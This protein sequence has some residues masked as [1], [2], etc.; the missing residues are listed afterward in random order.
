[1]RIGELAA[2]S[3]LPTSTIRY[4]EPIGVLPEPTRVSGQRRYATDAVHFLALRLARACGFRLNEMHHRLDRFD[5]GVSAS[6]RWRTLT[7]KK[8][9]E[10]DLRLAQ[11]K[12]MRRLVD[13]VSGR[14]CADL[15]DCG[16]LAGSVMSAATR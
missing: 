5:S 1:M 11:L 2:A 9:Q 8:L 10:L 14:K 6:D 7:Q 12:A 13:P 4:W 3:D 16:R 15:S